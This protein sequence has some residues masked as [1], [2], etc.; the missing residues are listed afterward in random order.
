[1]PRLQIL[2]Q[3]LE[4]LKENPEPFI[5]TKDTQTGRETEHPVVIS[6]VPLPENLERKDIAADLIS[7]FD[8][9]FEGN[10]E[11]T[12]QGSALA[13]FAHYSGRKALDD[14]RYLQRQTLVRF[15]N[16]TGRY[17]PAQRLPLWQKQSWDEWVS[18]M[19][20]GKSLPEVARK[21]LGHGL[22]PNNDAQTLEQESNS[23]S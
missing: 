8:A 17:V 21:L 9:C 23:G 4:I 16:E 15:N 7:I 5:W 22:V 6:V 12:M 18:Q 11:F 20:W 3:Y 13:I 1:M 2:D 19:E 14:H 10:W